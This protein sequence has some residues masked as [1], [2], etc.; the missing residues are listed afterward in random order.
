MPTRLKRPAFWRHLETLEAR[1]GA[2]AAEIEAYQHRVEL[3]R[4]NQLD[5]DIVTERARALLGMAMP[6][7]MVIMIDPATGKPI[8]GSS[9]G[10]TAN[11]ITTVSVDVSD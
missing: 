6:G 3:F 5:P 8:S 2:L 11:Q 1:S 7:D 9:V 10:V 4:S